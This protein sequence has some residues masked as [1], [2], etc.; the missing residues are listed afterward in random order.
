MKHTLF[1]VLLALI[2][3]SSF[4]YAQEQ[5]KI[6]KNLENIAGRY[7]ECTAYYEIVSHAMNLS[8]DEKTANIYKELA[9]TAMF[10]SLLIANEG[11]TKEMA[12][13]VTNSRIEMYK[14]KMKQETNNRNENI[15]IL[16]NNYHFDCEKLI[17]NQPDEV[18]HILKNEFENSSKE[19]Q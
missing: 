15:S 10:Y 3:C 16:I 7:A 9:N 5:K 8:N 11:R 14:K 12:V 19:K 18:F 1:F 2:A 6:D 4:S 13:N 17:K